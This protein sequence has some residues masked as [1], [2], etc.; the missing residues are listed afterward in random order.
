MWN[1]LAKQQEKEK[2]LATQGS[3]QQEERLRYKG[4]HLLLQ[5]ALLSEMRFC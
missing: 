3:E 5:T 4:Y 1:H 2:A